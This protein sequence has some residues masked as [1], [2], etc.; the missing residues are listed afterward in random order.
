MNT[1]D[2][3]RRREGEPSNR[4]LSAA[5]AYVLQQPGPDPEP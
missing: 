4:E 2:G 5:L 3:T 1:Y